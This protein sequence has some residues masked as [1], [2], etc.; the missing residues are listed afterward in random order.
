MT[1]IYESSLVCWGFAL[2][3]MSAYAVQVT[4]NQFSSSASVIT[5]ETGSTGLPAV[6]GVQFSGGDATFATPQMRRIGDQYFG[7]LNG[8]S[9][10]DIYFDQPQQAVGAYIIDRTPFDAVV[11]VIQ[12]AYDHD[13]NVI[14]TQSALYPGWGFPLVFLGIGEPTAQIWRVQ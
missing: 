4:T 8:S 5:F 7:N 14:E 2:S 12:I 3:I 1:T 13:N 6:S 9:Y 11:G 10:L